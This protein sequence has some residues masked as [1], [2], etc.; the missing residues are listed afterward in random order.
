MNPFRLLQTP[1]LSHGGTFSTQVL[2]SSTTKIGARW[3]APKSGNINRISFFVTALSGTPTLR[4]GIQGISGGL[5]DGSWI[6]SATVVPSTN[7]NRVTIPNVAVTADTQYATVVE[8]DSGATSATVRQRSNAPYVVVPHTCVSLAN[9]AGTWSANVDAFPCVATQ[10]TDGDVPYLSAMAAESALT[11]NDASNPD[12]YGNKFVP[13]ANMY[14][15]GALAIIRDNG[16]STVSGKIGL[17][18]SSGTELSSTNHSGSI[19][20][21]LT[22]QQRIVRYWSPVLLVRNQTYYLSLKAT[23]ASSSII[24][25]SVPLYYDDLAAATTG[26]LIRVSRNNL[27]A[28]TESPSEYITIYPLVSDFAGGSSPLIGSGGLI[29]VI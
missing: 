4:V 9:T 1:L 22:T 5:P 16:T 2:S 15:H 17:F 24:T 21:L 6:Q 13:D 19:D 28:W 27:G 10:Y 12:E 25:Y 3:R 18:D 7:Q 8:Y 23:H 26:G 14:C 29:S 20:S 11:Y